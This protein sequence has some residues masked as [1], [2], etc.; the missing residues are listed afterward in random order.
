MKGRLVDE[1]DPYLVA[2][3]SFNFRLRAVGFH[4]RNLMKFI[5]SIPQR[6]REYEMDSRSKGVNGWTLHRGGEFAGDVL[7]LFESVLFNTVSLLDYFGNLV[8]CSLLKGHIINK[9]PNLQ[10]AC[11]DKNNSFFN[12]LKIASLV[13][14][15]DNEIVDQLYGLRSN[16]IH[17]KTMKI[18]VVSE[19]DVRACDF[20]VTVDVP[21]EV[22]K[23][24]KGL[25]NSDAQPI[26]DFTFWLLDQVF[27]SIDLILKELQSDLEANRKVPVEKEI[28]LHQRIS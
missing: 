3:S 8:S 25:K 17:N 15:F 23:K 16:V 7:H 21:N 28:F 13:N 2:R 26:M 18:N 20:K 6:L 10:R 14:S 4:L 27:N 9:W 22:V 5:D 11:I 19:W 12:Q 1:K 24:F